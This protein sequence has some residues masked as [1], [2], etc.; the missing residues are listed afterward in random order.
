MT[1][2]SIHRP[3]FQ[4]PAGRHRGTDPRRHAS[5]RSRALPPRRLGRFRDP[6]GEATVSAHCSHRRREQDRQQL[7]LP[8]FRP[9]RSRLGDGAWS[10]TRGMRP[11]NAY[12]LEPGKT[13]IFLGSHG[14]EP[15]SAMNCYA[16]GNEGSA[17]ATKMPIRDG[18]N[19]GSE[20]FNVL[21]LGV[22]SI[23]RT[24]SEG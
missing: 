20:I 13:D 18:C 5:G 10:A 3:T 4:V 9:G 15:R 24:K 1:L 21:L 23:G 2:P 14:I 19:A 7:L 8:S 6:F 11:Y 16:I 12:R 22:R 17:R